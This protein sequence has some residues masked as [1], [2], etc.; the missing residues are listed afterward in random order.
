ME[1][2]FPV[3][4]NGRKLCFAKKLLLLLFLHWIMFDLDEIY[5]GSFLPSDGLAG[6]VSFWF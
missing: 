5:E 1:I 2:S 6:I 4:F 3:S